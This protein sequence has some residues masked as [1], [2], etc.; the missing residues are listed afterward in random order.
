[1]CVCVC[2]RH[3]S[4]NSFSD[5][6][7]SL[8]FFSDVDVSLNS[9]SDVVSSLNSFSDANL[10]LNFFS[11]VDPS[12]NSFSDVD[13]A[14]NFFLDVDEAHEPPNLSIQMWTSQSGWV[15]DMQGTHSLA[16]LTNPH[17]KTT[18]TFLILSFASVAL[19]ALASARSALAL[20]TPYVFERAHMY[21]I[22]A[23]NH[24]AERVRQPASRHRSPGRAVSHHT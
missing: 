16:A 5:V 2:A 22:H 23:L 18:A 15:A 21:M 19:A 9:F 13:L 4:I 14:L 1:V 10:S 6:D 7:S 17:R 3:P 11:D 24:D 8:N 12:F 20:N